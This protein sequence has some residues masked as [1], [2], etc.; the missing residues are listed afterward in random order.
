ME[1]N[2][3]YKYWDLY[4]VFNYNLKEACEISWFEADI[5]YN[6]IGNTPGV[7]PD[8][9]LL[10]VNLIKK[11]S[12][13]KV[14]EIGSGFSSLFLK[15]ACVDTGAIFIS[16]EEDEK[17][18]KMTQSLLEAHKLD[19]SCVLPFECTDKIDFSNTDMVFVDGTKDNRHRLLESSLLFSIPIVIVDDFESPDF[20]SACYTFLMNS[21]R[22]SF[23]VYNGVGRIDRHQFISYLTTSYLYT[24]FFLLKFVTDEMPR[25]GVW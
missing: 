16:Y 21:K 1:M 4:Q 25:L 6:K 19:S 22:S 9:A 11:L 13:K 17:Y 8:T 23:Y 12:M 3:S 20:I 15:K 5:I 10:L 14:L 18:R 7:Y 24:D 2:N